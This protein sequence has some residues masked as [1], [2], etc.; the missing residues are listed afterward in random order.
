MQV[1]IIVTGGIIILAILDFFLEP[2]VLRRILEKYPE[3][4]KIV[5]YF[6]RE[7]NIKVCTLPRGIFTGALQDDEYEKIKKWLYA[8][9]QVIQYI[10]E[11]AK[12][13]V[14]DITFS[15]SGRYQ[16]CASTRHIK[17]YL[18]PAS[19]ASGRSSRKY[20][21]SSDKDKVHLK[22]RRMFTWIHEFGH[23]WHRSKEGLAKNEEIKKNFDKAVTKYAKYMN[24][25]ENFADAFAM[26]VL[27]P[28]YLKNNFPQTYQWLKQNV[29][30]GQEYDLEYP[31]PRSI[32]DDLTENY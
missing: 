14:N 8:L 27:M 19:G 23:E 28:D 20:R 17:V 29:Y 6:Y 24:Y 13:Y 31:V 7:Y 3:L 15:S 21:T 18:A 22:E 11:E 16:A 5:D 30:H 25:R 26:Y 12:N 10:P 1:V 2:R 4:Q 9:K 32:R